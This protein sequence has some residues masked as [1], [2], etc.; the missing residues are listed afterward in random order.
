MCH[1]CPLFRLRQRRMK[2]TISSFL[3]LPTL[4]SMLVVTGCS[5]SRSS[6]VGSEARQES[7]STA[8][9]AAS[10]HL[11]A[12]IQELMEDE[13]DP[14]ADALWGAVGTTTTRDGLQERRPQTDEA[15]KSLRREAIIL[16]EATN[17]LRMQGRTVARA[18]FPSEGPGA[19]SSQEIQAKLDGDRVLFDRFAQALSAAGQQALAAIDAQDPAALLQAGE[20]LDAICEA[21]HVAHWYPRQVIPALP[22]SPPPPP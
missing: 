3:L 16:I 5:R 2:R 10:T 7:A 1:P 9:A 14:A 12:T 19:L 13:I 4:I 15:W 18:P 8:S 17:L 11:T 21:C 6:P 20:A 22:A